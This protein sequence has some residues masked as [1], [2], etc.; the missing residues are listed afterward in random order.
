MSF[1]DSFAYEKLRT[2]RQ[3]KHGCFLLRESQFN[4]DE[5]FLDIC[6]EEKQLPTTFSIVRLPDG[7][8]TFA[9]LDC[10][11]CPSVRELLATYTNGTE[12]LGIPGFELKECLPSSE[13]GT[14]LRKTW[15]L[16]HHVLMHLVADM[17]DLLLCRRKPVTLDA[18]VDS[19]PSVQL[20]VCIPPQSV[21][22]YGGSAVQS[23]LNGRFT[24]VQRGVWRQGH[25]EHVDIAR[26]LLKQEFHKTLAQVP[27]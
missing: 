2:K 24:V 7:M 22:L 16:K 21:Q 3:N 1:S 5:Y 25:D 17:S 11:P 4:Y 23:E 19:S 27:Q 8:W 13:N 14:S 12:L 10:S 20:P 9:G 6:L 18:L 26:K 15:C